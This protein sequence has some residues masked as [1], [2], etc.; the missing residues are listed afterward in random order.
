MLKTI[1]T[2]AQKRSALDDLRGR[3]R[4]SACE[5]ATAGTGTIM[6]DWEGFA[7]RTSRALENFDAVG[8]RLVLSFSR[9]VRM[10]RSKSGEMSDRIVEGGMTGSWTTCRRVSMA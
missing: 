1:R 10:R 8:N 6:A 3:S 7:A 2:T 9:A 4:T 5:G